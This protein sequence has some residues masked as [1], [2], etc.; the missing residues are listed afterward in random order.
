LT[1]VEDNLVGKLTFTVTLTGILQ[2]EFSIDYSTF[3]GTG[4][5]ADIDYTATNGTL[6]FAPGENSKTVTVVIISDKKTELDETLT[7][8]LTNPTTDGRGITVDKPSGIGTIV[9]DD[10]SPI[11]S[12]IAKTGTEDNNVYFLSTDFNSA[13]SDI[14]TDPLINIKVISLPTNGIL[15]L[16]GSPISISRTIP[17]SQLGNIIFAPFANWFGVTSFDYNATDGINW[18]IA[19]A[20]VTITINTVNDLPVAT[21]DQV[22]LEENTFVSGNILTNDSDLENSIEVSLYTINGAS[23]SS[24]TTAIIPNIGTITINRDGIFTFTPDLDYF[25]VLPVI[26]YTISDE[27]GGTAN[28]NL[29][30]TVT[31][32]VIDFSASS[33]CNNDA[34]YVNYCL[35]TANFDTS[36]FTAS[37]KWIDSEGNVIYSE[38]GLPF[39]GQLTWPGIVFDSSGQVTDWPGWIFV[40]GE[41]IPGSDGFETLRP[42]ATLVF[43]VNPTD[44]IVVNY[45]PPTPQCSAN[46]PA[47]PVARPDLVTTSEDTPI[48]IEALINDSFG[49]DGPAVG[50]LSVTIQPTHG[51]VIVNDGGTPENILDDR[52]NYTPDPNFTGTDS[53][54]YTICDSS[55]DCSTA[56]ITITVTSENDIPKAIN[57]V[58]TTNEN[59]SYSGKV[60]TNDILSGDGG[61]VWSLVNSSSSGTLVFNSDGTF[62]YT[63]DNNFSG[64]DFFTYQLCD[65]DGDCSTATVNFTVTCG[66][67][68]APT[69]ALTQPTC[70][71]ATGNIQVSSP[72]PGNEISFT[73]T[74]INPVVAAQTNKTGQFEN[75]ASGVYEVFVTNNYGCTSSSSSA[76][77]FATPIQPLLPEALI[78]Q[79]SCILSTGSLQITVPV[80]ASLE[81]SINEGQTWQSSTLFSGLAAN[82]TYTISVRIRNAS[83]A[84]VSSS[85]FIINAAPLAPVA[86][87]GP[88][89]S[90]G[91][92]TTYKISHAAVSNAISY[93]W[94]TS[95]TGTFSYASQIDPVYTPSAADF[96]SGVVTLTLTVKGEST[97]LE[98]SDSMIL[99]LSSQIIVNAG[100]DAA[101]CGT[102]SYTLATATV[103][104]TATVLWSTSGTGTFSNANQINPIYTPSSADIANGQVVLTLS[105]GKVADSMVLSLSASPAISAGPDRVACSGEIV[106]ISN[107]SASNYSGITWTSRS[108]GDISGSN[109]LNPTFIPASNTSG[110]VILVAIVSGIGYCGTETSSDSMIIRYSEPLVV[111]AGESDTIFYNTRANLSVAVNPENRNYTYSWSPED[112]V[113][114]SSSNLTETT[115]LTTNTLFVVTVTDVETGCQG[116]DSILVVIENNIDNLLEIYN[117][118]SPNG[119]GNND[120]WWIDGIEKF[121]DNEVLIF[122]RWG[123]KI[124]ELRNYDNNRVAWDGKNKQGNQVTDGTYY[125]LIK[126]NGIKSYTGWINLR[127]GSN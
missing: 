127:N 42:S 96:A 18:A 85:S 102:S 82:D 125:Y 25:G 69:V 107:V 88:D 72:Q 39:C 19:D 59:I 60:Q 53:F 49:P 62:T 2:D 10:H 113:Q 115:E 15:S 120:I 90:I 91:D 122:N 28:A 93:S 75:L 54:T 117:G 78:T 55:G 70:S 11:V 104:N 5:I 6:T 14:D 61:N 32:R 58:Y 41:W 116:K 63:P 79:P 27:N 22:T 84:C 118:M 109:T 16:G 73:V 103:V 83:P 21:D 110:E 51:I 45:P 50:P 89:E 20:N 99:S 80:D 121:L 56:T 7:V 24:G 74:G 36:G 77:I 35:E 68:S 95:G 100:E 38:S 124:I 86:D 46:P 1:M 108:P 37:V 13:Y 71:I 44:T 92:A 3:D 4:T 76:T 119:D 65:V 9:N 98:V 123:D 106:S 30:I 47:I 111:D 126:I 105:S 97:C 40:D 23:Y 64:T 66:V 8:E 17:N 87:A 29:F 67:I 94:A 34:A 57:D 112:L 33:F 114:N 43:S 52:L 26:S 48:V 31:E 12:N 81:Y 101:I